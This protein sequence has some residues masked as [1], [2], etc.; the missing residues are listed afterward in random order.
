MNLS[1][2]LIFH[3]MAGSVALASGA[4]ALLSSKGAWL[5]R[6]AGNAFFIAMFL[7]AIA[8]GA[9][10][11]L[12]PAAAA[13]NLIISAITM[14]MIATS[15]MTATRGDK[16]TSAFDIAACIA[17]FAIAA[18][19][20]LL[21][22]QAMGTPK[23]IGGIPSALFFSFA[24]IAALAALADVSV[25]MRGG[26]SGAQRIARHLWR[27]SFAMFLATLAFFV[28]QGAKIFPPAIRATGLLPVPM[29]I[30]LVL[31]LFWLWRVLLTNWWQKK[32]A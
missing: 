23:G 16:Q 25:I 4:T 3:I 20:A 24:A 27:M 5:H 18:G 10:A 26:V 13:F 30:V 12:R 11:V 28:G 22:V 32:S 2:L 1:A 19:A 15:W 31:M 21:G 7:M 29:L 8:G 9:L 17:A 14:Y 6:T